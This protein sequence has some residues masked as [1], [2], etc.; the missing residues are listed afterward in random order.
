MPHCTRFH[1]C[2]GAAA[3]RHWIA[4]EAH[5]GAV[6]ASTSPCRKTIFPDLLVDMVGEF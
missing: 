3:R 2:S 1:L 6:T 5:D 4:W